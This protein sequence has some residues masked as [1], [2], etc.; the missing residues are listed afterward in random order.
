MKHLLFLPTFFI[1][2]SSVS[3]Q[4]WKL[5]YHNDAEG[6]ALEGNIEELIQAVY[7]GK[8]VRV[9]WWSRKNEEGVSRV[10]HVADAAFLTIMMDSVVMAQ[11]RPIYGQTPEF[12]NYTITLKENL[13]WVQIT[14]TNGNHDSMMSN[15]S[16]GEIVGHGIRKAGAK[17]YVK[18]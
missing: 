7:D 17:W 11:I 12:E 13:E 10:Y 14:G 8:E 3:A 6:N 9:A 2:L 1:A 18:Q 15:T 4:D 5:V 16:T